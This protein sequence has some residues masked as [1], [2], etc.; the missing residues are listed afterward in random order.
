M[1][2]TYIGDMPRALFA[3]DNWRFLQVERKEARCGDI[4]FVKSKRS[5]REI[6]HM[7]I[8]VDAHWIFHCSRRLN[9]AAFE[10]NRSFFSSYEQKLSAAGMLKNTDPRSA[11]PLTSS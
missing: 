7:A 4:I 5:K 11:K 6:T 3:L 1:P 8:V 9:G 10:S 2:V